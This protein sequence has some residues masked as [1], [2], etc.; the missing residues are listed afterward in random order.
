VPTVWNIHYQRW[1]ID[2][3]EPERSVGERFQRFAV[4]FDAPIQIVRVP[5]SAKSATEAPDYGHAVVAEVVHVSPI[6]A[7]IDFG[8]RAVGRSALLPVST[9]IGDYVAG[10]I[11]LFLP[12]CA[13]ALPDD[14]LEAMAHDW[15]V[16]A[17]LA[18]MTHYAA[19][20]QSASWFIRDAQRVEYHQ[21]ASTRQQNANAY[22]LRCSLVRKN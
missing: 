3:G 17:V 15:S 14:I 8:L 11:K 7:V 2:D 9:Q 13:D 20:D 22:V 1:V 4:E 6:V 18:D 10:P 19:G 5:E 21:V 12:L 16:D